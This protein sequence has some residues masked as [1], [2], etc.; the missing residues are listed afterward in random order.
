MYFEDNCDRCGLRMVSDQKQRPERGRLLCVSCTPRPS[1]ATPA[2]IRELR[3]TDIRCRAEGCG[4]GPGEGCQETSPRCLI[5]EGGLQKLVH[6]LRVNEWS[7]LNEAGWEWQEV[8]PR[9]AGARKER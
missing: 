5:V 4:A 8:D 9:D 1:T 6:P 7:E 3:V 2:K